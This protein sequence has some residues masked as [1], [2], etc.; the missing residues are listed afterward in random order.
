MKPEETRKKEDRIDEIR[1]QIDEIPA[2]LDG[3]LMSKR[4]RVKRKDG[5]VH[6]SPE[7]WTFQYRGADGKRK[8]KR[9]PRNAKAVVGRLVRA[10]ERYRALE[11]E[12]TALRT[13]LALADGGKK[14][15]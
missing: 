8:W 12:H 15:D 13:E 4:N 2:L 3:A 10:G 7:H 14:N 9:I 5:R 11:R 1:R 6:V